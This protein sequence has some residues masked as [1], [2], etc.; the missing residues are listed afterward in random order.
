MFLKTT[1]LKEFSVLPPSILAFPFSRIFFR[2]W[3]KV[4]LLKVASI[5]KRFSYFLYRWWNTV[6]ASLTLS[7]CAF[8]PVKKYRWRAYKAYISVDFQHET[9]HRPSV[10][11]IANHISWSLP[12]S[13]FAFLTTLFLT[14]KGVYSYQQFPMRDQ[15]HWHEHGHYNNMSHLAR[16]PTP[17]DFTYCVILPI[18]TEPELAAWYIRSLFS[19]YWLHSR[20]STVLFVL[21]VQTALICLTDADNPGLAYLFSLQ[22]VVGY[23]LKFVP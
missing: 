12:I 2:L 21:N 16:L 1:N 9:F 17:S 22:S 10:I 18:C 4:A 14:K 7:Y 5:S 23:P 15:C 6:S 3:E 20:I 13:N 19:Y 8:T 11:V